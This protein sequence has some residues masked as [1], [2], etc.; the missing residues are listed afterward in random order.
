[1]SAAAGPAAVIARIAAAVWLA[2][3]FVPAAWASDVDCAEMIKN[4]AEVL[5][6]GSGPRNPGGWDFVRNLLGSGDATADTAAAP[7][8]PRY[9]MTIGQGTANTFD[10]DRGTIVS[11]IYYPVGLISQ[12]VG[13]VTVRGRPHLVL[14]TEYG[15]NVALL[16]ERVVEI[17]PQ[18]VFVVATES[19]R[20]RVCRLE[21]GERAAD[22]D[23]QVPSEASPA[24]GPDSGYI[25]VDDAATAE[26]LR[27]TAS[28]LAEIHRGVADGRSIADIAEL[29]P[30][31]MRAFCAP[32]SVS[33]F[34]E[35]GA[36]P[37]HPLAHSPVAFSFCARSTGPTGLLVPRRLRVVDFAAAEEAAAFIWQSFVFRNSPVI[38]VL[39]RIAEADL[40]PTPVLQRCQDHY[41]FEHS[42]TAELVGGLG[43]EFGVATAAAKARLATR[44][45][46]V[47]EK[48]KGEMRWTSSHVFV[49]QDPTEPPRGLD[50]FND[51]VL[52]MDCGDDQTPQ[53]VVEILLEHPRLSESQ[54]ILVAADLLDHYVSYFEEGT[55]LARKTSS[56]TELANGIFWR[57]SEQ[58][59]YFYWRDV[60]LEYLES[61]QP[62]LD[63]RP[64]YEENYERI[65]MYFAHVI[66]AAVFSSSV[67]DSAAPASPMQFDRPPPSPPERP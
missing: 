56:A 54:A 1:M 47:M 27:W 8:E 3:Q 42:R 55:D 11:S 19:D 31:I 16:P 51:I 63:L 40:E 50:W 65:R 62:I 58:A 46:H 17:T 44:G 53:R 61:V 13:E 25:H 36:K 37:D 59:E 20:T 4:A 9:Y 57:I 41:R 14:R 32:I 10:C 21:D 26:W 12:H 35:A 39:A 23:P 45:A 38:D 43:V 5:E 52:R 49:D 29:Q 60:I 2:T 6:P 24:I 15:I 33:S 34:Y 48:P 64:L 7:A 18:D 67:K 28:V 22:C 66:M 30:E